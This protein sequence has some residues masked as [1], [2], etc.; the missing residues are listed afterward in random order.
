MLKSVSKE[1]ASDLV[2]IPKFNKPETSYL[3]Y[4]LAYFSKFNIIHNHCQGHAYE[5]IDL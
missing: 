3:F 2:L 5:W 1:D 4:F